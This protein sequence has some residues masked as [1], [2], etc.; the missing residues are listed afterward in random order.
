MIG[1]DIGGIPELVKENE[2]GYLF[3]PS[4][5]DSIRKAVARA[6]AIG[7]AGYAAMSANAF[8]FATKHFDAELH[9]A[10][11]LEIYKSVIHHP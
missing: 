2:T 1:S 7:D 11:L 10:S 9:Y 5:V 4:S 6:Q 3:K 8:D